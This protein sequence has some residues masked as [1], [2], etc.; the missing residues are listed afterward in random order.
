MGAFE[1]VQGG[2]LVRGLSDWETNF[3]A[4][5]AVYSSYEDGLTTT[6]SKLPGSYRD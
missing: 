3:Q 1:T 2:M 5:L 4:E 6:E